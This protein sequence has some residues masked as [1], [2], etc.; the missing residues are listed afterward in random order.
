MNPNQKIHDLL[1]EL[2]SEFEKHTSTETAYGQKAYMKNQFEFYGIKTPM[3]QEIQRLF[4]NKKFLPPKAK[5]ETLTKALWSKPQREFQYFAQEFVQC[6]ATKFEKNDIRLF[7]FMITHK[8][9]WDT[10]DFIA[11]KLVGEYFKTFPEER[12]KHI[13]K[14][15]A[16]GNLWLQRTAVLFQL[17]YKK[18]VDTELL[19]RVINPLLGSGEFFINKAIG[20]MLREYSKTNPEWVFDFCNR[21]SLDKLSR[22]EAL[23]LIL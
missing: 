20:W 11:S 9:W 5:L 10:V 18:S 6:Y 1:D 3:R 7:Q 4:L 17:K 21:T 8:S 12:E 15:I 19:S 2:E 22:K 14:W 23:R 16:S 13:G